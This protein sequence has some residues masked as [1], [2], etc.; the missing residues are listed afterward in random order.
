MGWSEFNSR[1]GLE[2]FPFDT[3]S[4]LALGPNEPPIQWVLRALTLGVK[5]PGCET[6][7]SPLSSAEVKESVELYLYSTDTSSWHGAWLSTELHDLYYTQHKR[8]VI[9]SMRMSEAG[10]VARIGVKKK[11][12]QN[13]NWKWLLGWCRR[14]WENSITLH[15]KGIGCEDV[16]WI[17]L[18]QDR[19][20]WQALVNRWIN[21]CV[22]KIPGYF[23]SIWANVGSMQW[24][25]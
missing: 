24:V 11:F 10:H 3:M 22:P 21:F 19:V 18:V 25:G 13:M 4:R 1:R 15:V 23:L 2:I 5:R 14:R 8:R 9:K 12:V 16:D 17:H 20:Q 6:V 7:H